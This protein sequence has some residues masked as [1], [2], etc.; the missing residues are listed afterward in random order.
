MV[1]R[2]SSRSR[3]NPERSRGGLWGRGAEWRGLRSSGSM[4]KYSGGACRCVV[5]ARDEE[6][7]GPR[8]GIERG[9]FGLR[10]SVAKHGGTCGCTGGSSPRREARF[11]TAVW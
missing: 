9:W 5:T 7:K 3:C 6:A 2:R 4:G 8:L 11:V 1:A 10:S